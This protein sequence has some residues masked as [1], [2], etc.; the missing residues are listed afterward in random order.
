MSVIY[1]RE[2]FDAVPM[3]ADAFYCPACNRH[4]DDYGL[5]TCGE[6]KAGPCYEFGKGSGSLTSAEVEAYLNSRLKHSL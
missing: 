3:V 2:D 4:W 5:K 6:L 1:K